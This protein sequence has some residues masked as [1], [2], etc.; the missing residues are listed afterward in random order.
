[1]KKNTFNSR[2]YQG[3]LER[4]LIIG[5]IALLVIVGGG[6]IY[7]FWGQTAFVTAAGCFGLFGGLI[8]FV[9]L[10]LGLLGRLGG[11]N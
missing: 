5:G 3:R 6:L 11:S 8:V 4:E 1:M 2:K 7:L 9:W 10:L